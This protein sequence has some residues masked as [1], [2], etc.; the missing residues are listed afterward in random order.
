MEI[1][2]VALA[3]LVITRFFGEVAVRFGQPAL[4]GEIISGIVLGLGIGW[5]TDISPLLEY[6]AGPQQ[7]EVL[8]LTESTIFIALTDLGMFFL[9]LHG[10]LELRASDLAAASWRA[11]LVAL[12][13]LLLPL[14]SGFGLSWIFLP[15]SEIK[16]AQ[17][18][19]VG[20]ALAITAVPVTIKVLMDL[21]KLKTA[22]GSI[23]VS[24]AVFDDVLSLLLLS[25]LT[26][27]L[28]TG[29]L[30]DLRG[31]LLLGGRIALFAVITI[32]IGYYLFPVVGRRL[33]RMRTAE[34]EFTALVV[35]AMTFA[36]LAELLGLHFVVGAFLAGLFFEKRTAGAP[37][38]ANV[39][40][41]VSGITTGFL[42]PLFFASIGLSLDLG[43]V[44]TIPLF[45]VLL[46]LCAMF[47]KLLGA[48]LPAYALGFSKRDAA[49]VGVGMSGRGA[50]E[51]IVA[52]IALRA[53]LF[54]QP[55]PPHPIV[56][57]LF[58]AIVIVAIVTTL[59]VPILLKLVFRGRRDQGR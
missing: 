29:S 26:S 24:A 7:P 17:C 37:T 16:V 4:V 30:P 46:I 43:A 35:V 15:E 23:I 8:Q 13:G 10:G 50:V 11:F 34:F 49:A 59:A 2:I 52:G 41:K 54:E 1:L 6:Y 42:A 55:D 20:T 57:N 39:E 9:M 47:A 28:D 27:V 19:F 32:G 45:L 18:L 14:A 44:T 21:G 3:L 48:G 25:V 31:L 38:Y 56:E 40:R 22:M 58:S 51:L 36:V 33:G 12:G 53:G 5:Y